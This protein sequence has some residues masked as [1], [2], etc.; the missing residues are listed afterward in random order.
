[1]RI[2][3]YLARGCN[4]TCLVLQ[5]LVTFLP[6]PSSPSL[7]HDIKDEMKPK[8]HALPS[9]FP[10]PS[11]AVLRR[12]TTIT[13][14]GI[15]IPPLYRLRLNFECR[16]FSHPLSLSFPLFSLPI[17]ERACCLPVKRQRI[18]PLLNQYCANLSATP[19]H[20]RSLISARRYHPLLLLCPPSTEPDMPSK[21]SIVYPPHFRPSFPSPLFPRYRSVCK[22]WTTS[23]HG[24]ERKWER[25]DETA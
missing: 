17:V 19:N 20:A 13:G 5:P 2:L 21:E 23:R 4:S 3:R 8:Y 24:R 15:S 16:E 25:P 12:I 22:Y 1:M 11:L 14:G 10:P 6:S 18:H 9:P 7:V